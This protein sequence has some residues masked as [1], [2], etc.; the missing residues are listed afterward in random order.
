MSKKEIP[1][2]SKLWKI[3]SFQRDYDRI[4]LI[5]RPSKLNTCEQILNAKKKKINKTMSRAMKGKLW[6]GTNISDMFFFKFF[7]SCR[8]FLF[9]NMNN[10]SR[11]KK[12]KT[13]QKISEGKVWTVVVHEREL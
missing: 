5:Q 9:L 3:R 11:C 7:S 13:K 1:G 4:N 10:N 6:E 8:S 2:H 12:K